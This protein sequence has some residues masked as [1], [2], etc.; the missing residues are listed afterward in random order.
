MASLQ[1]EVDRLHA[2]ADD[3]LIVVHDS[4]G[5]EVKYQKLIAETA[6]L[7]LFYS[8]EGVVMNMGFKLLTNS[9]YADGTRPALSVPPYRGMAAAEGAVLAAAKTRGARFLKW[10]QLSDFQR[11]RPRL[12]PPP[13]TCLFRGEFWTR[14]S[15]T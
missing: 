14:C 15:R 5:L 6:L 2:L 1:I 7:R 3:L 12:C 9:P 13:S 8:L 11:N 4:F 10:T